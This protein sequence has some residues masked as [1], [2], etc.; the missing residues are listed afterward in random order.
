MQEIMQQAAQGLRGLAMAHET[1]RP[2]YA[3]LNNG[4]LS[5]FLP[6]PAHLADRT[7]ALVS[8]VDSFYRVL[9]FWHG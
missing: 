4:L 2:P 5:L 7:A 1:W 3:T 6:S 8:P 9:P